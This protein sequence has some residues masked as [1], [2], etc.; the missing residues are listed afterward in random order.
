MARA[1]RTGEQQR[2]HHLAEAER[3]REP[4]VR[5][6]A[7]GEVLQ[8]DVTHTADAMRDAFVGAE[9]NA[10]RDDLCPQFVVARMIERYAFVRRVGQDVDAAEPE[11]VYAPPCLCDRQIDVAQIERADTVNTS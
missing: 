2:R 11:L 6:G 5:D 7:S 3:R 9:R 1:D 10:E 4:R 8:T